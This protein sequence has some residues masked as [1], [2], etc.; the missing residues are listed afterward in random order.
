MSAIRQRR[1]LLEQTQK[2]FSIRCKNFLS[3]K[4]VYHVR[5]VS[6]DRSIDSS[7]NCSRFSSGSRIWRSVRI[8]RQRIAS[9]RGKNH[10]TFASVQS[11]L[12]LVEEL[13]ESAFQRSLSGQ[14]RS[15]SES[16]RRASSLQAYISQMRPIY[17][18]E[19]H[20]FVESARIGVTRGVGQTPDKRAAGSV[21]TLNSNRRDK[22][23]AQ[24]P[25]FGAGF[26]SDPFSLKNTPKDFRLRSDKVNSRRISTFSFGETSADLRA[27]YHA[28]YAG[29]SRRTNILC[30]IFQLCRRRSTGWR[31]EKDEAKRIEL[32][33]LLRRPAKRPKERKISIRRD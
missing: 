31:G 1:E 2:A 10:A 14:F 7:S 5:N 9:S 17:A 16:D 15:V 26:D 27:C 25:S 12:P 19:I 32:F 13:V 6:L 18:K 30:K 20:G 3:S 22:Q 4:F 24:T 33:R 23:H 11:A 8:R 28:N 29:R 21:A